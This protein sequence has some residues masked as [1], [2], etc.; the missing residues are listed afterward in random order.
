MKKLT[1]FIAGVAMMAL[2]SP[3]YAAGDSSKTTVSENMPGS[4]QSMSAGEIE[5]Y[6]VFSPAGEKLGLIRSVNTDSMSG[7]IKFITIVKGGFAGIGG[8]EIAV[9]VQALQIDHTY[10]R[11]T[12]TVN[13]SKLDNAPQQ[14]Q[15]SDDEFQRNLEQ[16]YGIAPAWKGGSQQMGVDPSQSMDQQQP[17]MKTT[18]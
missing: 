17:G 4:A 2:A 7:Q 18:P 8:E 5:G 16:Y 9:P 3:L 6:R 14:A 15:M 1:T 12:L 11:A 13:E 10:R